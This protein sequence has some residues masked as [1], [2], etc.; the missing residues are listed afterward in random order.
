[1][2]YTYRLVC[3]VPFYPTLADGTLYGQPKT[4]PPGTAV[5]ILRATRWG[6]ALVS[7]DDSGVTMY[8]WVS[9]EKMV[10]A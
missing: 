8:S 3:T 2:D 4:F 6:S 9:A 1:M 5:T 10:Q 7:L